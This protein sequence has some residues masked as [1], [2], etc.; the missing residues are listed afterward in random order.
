MEDTPPHPWLTHPGRP[1]SHPG[2]ILIIDPDPAEA[3]ELCLALEQAGH[4]VLPAPDL[5]SALSIAAINPIHAVIYDLPE[6]AGAPDFTVLDALG[7][8]SLTA[9][10]PKIVLAR[11]APK[12]VRIEALRR[13]ADDVLAKPFDTEELALRLERRLVSNRAIGRSAAGPLLRHPL[14]LGTLPAPVMIGRYLLEEV[15]GQGAMGVVLR[16]V[17]PRLQ[18]PVAVKI[19]GRSAIQAEQWADVAEMEHEGAA[20]ARFDHAHIVKVFDAGLADGLPF[21]VMELVEG[22][23]LDSKLEHGPLEPLEAVKMARAV[24]SAL[25]EAHQNGWVH[26]D[27]KPANILIGRDGSI[28][29]TDFGLAGLFDDVEGG[30]RIFGTPGYAPPECLVGEPHTPLG[31]LFALGAVLYRALSGQAVFSSGSVSQRL[32]MTI[33]GRRTGLDELVPGLPR[34]L[35]QLVDSLLHSLPSG[36]PATA[37]LVVRRLEWLAQAMS[38]APLPNEELEPAETVPISSEVVH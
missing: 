32:A 18:R 4:R 7:R 19:L 11:R 14:A 24:A 35:Y 29:V 10:A 15:I 6:R 21:L 28:K 1:T 36:R 22:E 27:I 34:P 13:G 2:G 37:Q 26:R 9:S 38:Y 17:D 20:L 23:S 25:V 12:E 5:D 33:A 16:G 3:E 8:R 30:E 31:D